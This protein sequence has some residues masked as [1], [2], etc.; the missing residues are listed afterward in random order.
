MK[1]T[2]EAKRRGV[3]ILNRI[4]VTDLIA[5]NGQIAG[6]VGV[7]T[8]TGDVYFFK[9]KSVVLASGRS[10]RLSRNLT[11]IDFN[12]R[13]PPTLSGDGTSM[14]LRAGLPIINIEFLSGRRLLAAGNY[15]PNYGDPRNTTQPAGRIIDDAG[16]VVVPRTRFY[17]WETL[18]KKKV[19]AA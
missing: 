13:L 6:A 18:G 12:R 2:A 3:K 7:G 9:A 17:S 16:N 14:A 19:D 4:Q 8:R 1:L 11:G 15:Y 5:T 10:E